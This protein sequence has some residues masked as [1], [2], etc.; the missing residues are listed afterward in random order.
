[1]GEFRILGHDEK[2]ILRVPV[3]YAP[4]VF[5][6]HDPYDSLLQDENGKNAE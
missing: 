5:H 1:M 2:N 3:A 4:R 6:G